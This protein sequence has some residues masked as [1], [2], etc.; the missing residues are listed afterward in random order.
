VDLEQKNQLEQFLQQEQLTRE[1][2]EVVEH[3]LD[4]DLLVM[5][6]QES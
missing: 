2:A 1:A 6:D 5:E 3:F 4:Q